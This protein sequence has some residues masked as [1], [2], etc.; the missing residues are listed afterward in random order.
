MTV[1]GKV[2]NVTLVQT[3]LGTLS[4]IELDGFRGME[5]VSWDNPAIEVGRT[6]EMRVSFEWSRCNEEVH[7]YSPQLAFPCYSS[8][9]GLQAVQQETSYVS[10]AGH[11]E[12]GETEDDVV[13]TIQNIKDPLPLE[14]MTCTVA[15]GRYSWTD[16]FVDLFSF[17]GIGRE[18]RNGTDELRNMTSRISLN[19]T[20]EFMDNNGDRY[21][22]D[23]DVITLHN[24]TRPSTKSGVMTYLLLLTW[25]RSPA[26]HQYPEPPRAAVYLIMTAGGPL[27]QT[28]G[29]H[30]TP[31]ACVTQSHVPNG[32]AFTI[33]LVGR[34]ISWDDLEVSVQLD[35]GTRGAWFPMSADL[36]GGRETSWASRDQ[37][38]EA[39]F[40]MCNI[41]DVSGNGVMDAGD[42]ITI[43]ASDGWAF[44]VGESYGFQVLF[45]PTGCYMVDEKFRYLAAP[46]SDVRI[47]PGD[48]SAVF[49]FS[50]PYN[51]TDLNYT[52]V[53][54]PW[55]E[56][57]ISLA[58]GSQSVS[59]LPSTATLLGSSG[60][61]ASVTMTLGTLKLLLT[62][63]DLQGNGLVNTGD[64]LKLEVLEGDNFEGF[65]DYTLTLTYVPASS[66]LFETV[67]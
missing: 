63:R 45:E 20:I 12:V 67:I 60:T 31:H 19:G 51:G 22:D 54:V 3:T 7:V 14:N 39:P 21:F 17:Y 57:M 23:G 34:S 29:P 42:V 27:W 26:Q 46:S 58:E 11:F 37:T 64:S 2:T 66:V 18:S 6:M 30:L 62:I 16:E 47:E 65:V 61:Q 33:R 50:K 56:V 10:V 8:L 28:E 49:V 52:P 43:T 9:L 1:E 4:M 36:D 15:P 24:L 55:G 41:T 59:W 38:N 40:V 44:R 5:L 48:A 35:N 32:R 53:D 25:E 13:V